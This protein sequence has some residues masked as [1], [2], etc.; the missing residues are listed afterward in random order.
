MYPDCRQRRGAGRFGCTARTSVEICHLIV[1]LSGHPAKPVKPYRFAELKVA[2]EN[3]RQQQ[4]RVLRQI[5]RQR[6]LR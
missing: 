2:K 1:V 5:S 4:A 3:D 6:D